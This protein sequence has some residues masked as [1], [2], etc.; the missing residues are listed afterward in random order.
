VAGS[1]GFAGFD[2]TH[3]RDCLFE[4]GVAYRPLYGMRCWGGSVW[5]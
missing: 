4:L 3:A 2:R 5:V 1:V